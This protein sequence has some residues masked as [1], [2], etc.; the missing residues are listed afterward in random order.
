L[1]DQHAIHGHDQLAGKCDF[2]FFG[3]ARPDRRVAQ[4]LSA[5]LIGLIGRALRHDDFADPQPQAARQG[6]G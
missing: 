5:T 6:Q 4:V 2:A 1:V 3:P